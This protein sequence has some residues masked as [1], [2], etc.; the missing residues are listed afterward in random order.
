M[1]PR[2]DE[3]FDSSARRSLRSLLG[4]AIT[5]NGN[6]CTADCVVALAVTSVDSRDCEKPPKCK[7]NNRLSPSIH[8]GFTASWYSACYSK[9][10]LVVPTTEAWARGPNLTVSGRGRTMSEFAAGFRARHEE[11]E[12]RHRCACRSEY[13]SSLRGATFLATPEVRDSGPIPLATFRS[14]FEERRPA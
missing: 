3:L 13:F 6:L 2:R 8:L 5:A 7:G 14:M 12:E 10:R 1:L 4:I 11:Q 9:Q